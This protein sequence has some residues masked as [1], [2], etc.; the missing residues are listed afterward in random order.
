MPSTLFPCSDGA[1]M[2]TAG[3]DIQYDRLCEAVGRPDLATH[4][5][6][7]TNVERVKHRDALTE[8]F[9]AIFRT[10][11]VAHWLDTLD[12]HGIPSGPIN[13]IGQV[14]ADPQIRHRGL[15]V[16]TPHALAPD[17]RVI[18]SPLNFSETPITDYRAPP[19]LG[20]HT[21]DVLA[22]ELGLAEAELQVLRAAK[23]I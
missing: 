16:A 8:A 10:D 19:M 18:R 3:N 22:A 17:L 11:T 5:L 13:D 23:V 4:P 1:I 14:F 2:L 7:Y 21:F 12:A 15:E 6:F 20:E 9:D